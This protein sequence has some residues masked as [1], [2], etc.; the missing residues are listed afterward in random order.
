MEHLT[1]CPNARST[2][3]LEGARPRYPIAFA[4]NALPPRRRRPP[5]LAWPQPNPPT[6][7]QHPV[8]FVFVGKPWLCLSLFLDLSGPSSKGPEFDRRASTSFLR[9]GH[10]H[11]QGW[12][13]DSV[14]HPAATAV[15]SSNNNTM[16]SSLYLF[17]PL[18][19]CHQP[20]TGSFSF[21]LV[22]PRDGIEIGSPRV[23]QQAGIVV[24]D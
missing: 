23:S 14:H 20:Y 4:S 13:G 18:S 6:Q 15:Y 8:A 11:M 7:R 3:L 17:L 9:G 22:P 12:G 10:Q 21:E 19:L 1:P 24:S 5:R 16:S 2:A